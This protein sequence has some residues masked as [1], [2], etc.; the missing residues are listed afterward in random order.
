MA[1]ITAEYAP[2]DSHSRQL[3][4]LVAPGGVALPRTE[5][6]VSGAGATCLRAWSTRCLI[7]SSCHDGRDEATNCS[8]CLL[9]CTQ[10][11]SSKLV[12]HKMSGVH[13]CHPPR[14]RELKKRQS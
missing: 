4:E 11:P 14:M 2:A 8:V 9:D 3:H 7:L 1:L 10:C 5:A 12:T 13:C 6:G